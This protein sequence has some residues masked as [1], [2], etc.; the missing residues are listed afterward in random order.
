MELGHVQLASF[1]KSVGNTDLNSIYIDGGF[2]N[3]DLFL[4]LMNTYWKG[5]TVKTTRSPLGSVSETAMV[6][7]DQQI[8][9]RFLKT[10]YTMKK[11]EPLSLA[12]Q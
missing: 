11:H 2:T 10:P 7:S 6:F 12:N 5:Y 4:T 3:N 8:G 9:D 1:R